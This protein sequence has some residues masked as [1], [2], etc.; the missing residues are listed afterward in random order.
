MAQP[1]IIVYNIIANLHHPQGD[2]LHPCRCAWSEAT[3]RVG[4]DAVHGETALRDRYGGRVSAQAG[5]LKSPPAP[6]SSL[7]ATMAAREVTVRVSTPV[8]R[9]L[10]GV[11]TLLRGPPF[12][13]AQALLTQSAESRLI[14]SRLGGRENRCPKFEWE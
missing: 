14:L 9:T 3:L 5:G 2:R 1:F 12:L 13:L 11:P 6:F 4:D 8:T 7:R 10:G